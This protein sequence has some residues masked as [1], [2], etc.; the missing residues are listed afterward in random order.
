MSE[1]CVQK[2][3][4]DINQTINMI[5][6]QENCEKVAKFI[7]FLRKRAASDEKGKIFAKKCA[8]LCEKSFQLSHLNVLQSVEAI[9]DSFVN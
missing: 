1:I 6:F 5:A 3:D 7:H 9:S 8:F 2:Q 4:L